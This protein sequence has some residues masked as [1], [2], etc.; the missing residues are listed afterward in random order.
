MISQNGAT[1]SFEVPFRHCLAAVDASGRVL[2][3]QGDVNE[4]FPLAS[5]TKII[6]AFGAMVAWQQGAI[7]PAQEAGRDQ[8]GRPY[9]VAHLLSHSSGLDVEGDGTRFRDAPGR[10]RIYSNQGFEVLGRHLEASVQV[11]LSKWLDVQV[12]QPLGLRATV[13][14]SSPAR[15]GFGDAM[16]LTLLAE[17]LLRPTLLD[18]RVHSAFTSAVLPGLRGLLPGYGIQRNNEWGLGVEIKDHKQ[19]HWTPAAASPKTFG[20]FGMSGSYLWVDPVQGVAAV[21][22]GQEPFGPW[23]KEHWPTIGEQI[24]ARSVA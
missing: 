16:D 6:T 5:V 9:T 19:P 14:P 3:E 4:V 24:L 8:A 15:S 1:F 23:H 20:H 7:D 11:P 2:A 17:E 12:Y 18:P 13:I 21:F 10:R 22:L